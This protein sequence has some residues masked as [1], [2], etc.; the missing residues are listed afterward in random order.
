MFVMLEGQADVFVNNGGQD[1]HVATLYES[2]AFGE[3]SLL[4]GETRSADVIARTDCEVWEL[5]RSV[6]QPLLQENAE[7][8]SRLSQILAKRKLETDGVL[9]AYTPPAVVEQ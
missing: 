6:L 3:M 8:A 5:R 4:T 7:L 2:D 9:A 1:L